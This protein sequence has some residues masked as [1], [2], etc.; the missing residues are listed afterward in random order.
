MSLLQDPNLT[1]IFILENLLLKNTQNSSSIKFATT[2]SHGYLTVY[3]W[4]KNTNEVK[5]LKQF[6][7]DLDGLTTGC[8]ITMISDYNNPSKLPNFYQG[9]C[10]AVSS[11]SNLI[12]LF[13]VQLGITVKTF[14]AHDDYIFQLLFLINDMKLISVSED[15]V[16]KLW[17]IRTDIAAPVSI[18]NKPFKPKFHD[19]EDNPL[20]LMDHRADI[21]SVDFNKSIEKPRL[22]SLDRS[23]KLLIYNL[24][25]WKESEIEKIVLSLNLGLTDLVLQ[26][27]L[28][29]HHEE[30]SCKLGIDRVSQTEVTGC[31][32]II[33]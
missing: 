8:Q 2:N 19:F 20:C 12:H 13:S 30:S 29:F 1:S 14:I 6:L 3:E 17:D 10:I 23:G 25:P 4:N 7:V 33:N 26:C 21:V 9:E 16:I 31:L 18:P 27:R 5:K 22:A 11:K 15:R 24:K 28:V 32:L